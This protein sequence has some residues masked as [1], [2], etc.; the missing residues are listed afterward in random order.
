MML[1]RNTKLETDLFDHSTG[2]SIAIDIE[3]RSGGYLVL[4]LAQW[5][6]TIRD[7]EYQRTVDK[8]L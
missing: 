7:L 2:I 3:N 1:E 5:V 8:H 6:A 4:A